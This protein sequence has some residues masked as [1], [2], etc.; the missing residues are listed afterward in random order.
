MV[1]TAKIFDGA[2]ARI[3]VRIKCPSKDDAVSLIERAFP[4]HLV[5]FLMVDR[6]KEGQP[7]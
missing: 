4:E 1:I 3:V 7:C 2:G 5:A 6:G